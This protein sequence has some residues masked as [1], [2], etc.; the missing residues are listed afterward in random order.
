MKNQ[1]QD[2]QQAKRN[3][4]TFDEFIKVPDVMKITGFTRNYIYTL[5]CK[6][7][8]PHYKLMGSVRFKR[9]EIMEWLE[10]CK[11]QIWV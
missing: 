6:K 8:I 1:D 11:V 5:V 3:E 2:R 7:K 9:S 4:E 10:K